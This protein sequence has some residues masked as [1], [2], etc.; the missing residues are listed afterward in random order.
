MPTPVQIHGLLTQLDKAKIVNLDV[1]LRSL[2]RPEGMGGASL[3]G[4]DEGPAVLIHHDYVLIHIPR[5]ADERIRELS[6]VA[7]QVQ[8]S[9]G[10]G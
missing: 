10:M 2:V 3:N 6:A 4:A 9:A 8:R 1:P 5:V 7:R